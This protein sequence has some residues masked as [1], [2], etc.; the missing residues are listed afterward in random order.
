MYLG[1]LDQWKWNGR[2]QLRIGMM[3]YCTYIFYMLISLTHISAHCAGYVK[4]LELDFFV[5]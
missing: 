1:S 4:V 3:E 5:Y 2:M